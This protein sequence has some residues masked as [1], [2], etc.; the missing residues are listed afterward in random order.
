MRTRCIVTDSWPSRA[1]ERAMRA[2]G[3]RLK[4]EKCLRSTCAFNIADAGSGVKRVLGRRCGEGGRHEGDILGRLHPS[5]L[6][7]NSCMCQTAKCSG[8]ELYCTIYVRVARAATSHGWWRA[9]AAYLR[10]IPRGRSF[11]L[12]LTLP[13]SSPQLHAPSSITASHHEAVLGP[14]LL[15]AVLH[16]F[17][18]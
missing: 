6:G 9:V 15:V 4:S 10:Q 12:T 17:C 11:P 7:N 8:I 14:L 13:A 18:S 5:L 1:A 16:S 3:T 2:Y